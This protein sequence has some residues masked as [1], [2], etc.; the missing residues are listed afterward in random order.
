MSPFLCSDFLWK[1]WERERESGGEGGRGEY[2]IH[3]HIQ[4]PIT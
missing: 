1:R 3:I 2:D 4:N